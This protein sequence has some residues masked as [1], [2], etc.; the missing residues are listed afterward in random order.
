MR[1]ELGRILDLPSGEIDPATRFRDLGLDSL[2]AT[3]LAAAI[4]ER[5]GRPLPAIL[6]W[7]YPTLSSLAA[8]LAA[9]SRPDGTALVGTL[10]AA[11]A[12]DEP[13]AI[14]GMA[15][16]LPGGVASPE[17]FWD[18][19][20]NGIDAI[21]EVPA[22]RWPLNAYFDEDRTVP[23]HMNTRWGGF[24]DQIDGFDARFFSISPREAVETDPMQR[25]ALELA[26]EAVEEGGTLPA[27]LRGSRTG[28]FMGAMWSDY[29][30]LR[31][32][33][34]GHIQQHTG[35]GQDTSA[36]AGRIAYALGLQGPAMTVNTACSSSLVAIHLACR[37]L[38]D[39]ESDVALAGGVN[40]IL[41]PYGTVVMSKFGGMAPDGRCKAFDHRANGYVRGEGGAIVMLKR[42]SRALAD[43]D[44]VHGLIRGSAVNNDGFSNGFTAPNPNAQEAMLR[45]A[46]ARAGVDP[47]DIQYV[48]AHGTGT[49]L[50]DPIEA[51][52]LGAVLGRGRPPEQALR[53][54]SVKTNIGHLEAAAGV[55]GLIKV[56]LAMRH[57]LLPASLH[58]ERPNPAIP[59]DTLG[60]AVQGA[61]TPWPNPA[62]PPL[63]G[64][65]SFGFTG[66]NAHVL[67][68]GTVPAGEIMLPLS[69]PDGD[70]LRA[71]VQAIL[72]AVAGCADAAA[73]RAVCARAMAQ[74]QGSR[75]R[76]DAVRR[77]FRAAD[78]RAM[79]DRLL[80]A[81][82]SD[83]GAVPAG[84]RPPIV[85][86]YPGHGG[87]MP[88]MGRRLMAE[89]PIFRAALEAVSAAIE[90]HAGWSVLTELAGPPEQAR[91]HRADVVQP[92]LF[93]FQTAL[94]A[95]WRAW[96]IA[97]DL[98]IGHSVGE[99]A[100]AHT[101]GILD[102]DDAARLIVARG[103]LTAGVAG[104]GMAVIAAAPERFADLVDGRTL[105]W[106]GS[107]SPQSTL[108]TGAADALTHLLAVL[109]ERGI[110]AGRVNI[111]FA[112][113]GPAMAVLR[114]PLRQALAGIRPR[115]GAV[116]LVSTTTG[117]LLDGEESGADHWVR[118]LCDPVRF[119]DAVTRIAGL[120][121][122]PAFLEIGPD[123]VFGRAIE[124]TLATAG[125]RPAGHFPTLTREADGRDGAVDTLAALYERGCDVA[126]DRLGGQV[127]VEAPLLLPL[128]GRDEAACDQRVRD[129]AGWWRDHPDIPAA[130]IAFSA[131]RHRSHFVHRAA[132]AGIGQ[133]DLRR[134]LLSGEGMHRGS[135]AT[136]GRLVMV[137]PGQGWQWAGMGMMFGLQ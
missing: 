19:L 79:A 72:S 126:W 13:I 110:R 74:D 108:V 129:V 62:R 101:A 43:G 15:C 122:G 115:R 21:T 66:T 114:D 127:A 64:V 84:P 54:G 16:R 128:S 83:G 131:A 112:S 36:I 132:V 107:N 118:N 59:F 4:A 41:S 117:D 137:F 10:P 123:P 91:L 46:C 99:V 133:D 55:V 22:S 1:A 61:A 23:G 2:R 17:S 63:A 47:Q 92:V 90:R 28:I 95:L 98:V 5:L 56:V 76:D 27:S 30:R 88:G 31:G 42:L 124:E 39:G 96:G 113:H 134:R 29:A 50:G 75:N 26:W 125:H 85:F 68:E 65:S 6:L 53:I 102:L 77:V 70:G 116:P 48:E 120:A 32:T 11:A 82:A 34:T 40:L 58:L 3:G 103:R 20:R 37:S 60:L 8:F 121:A 69:A 73:L 109:K 24:L 106:A 12:A 86:L 35:T 45:E 18:L 111:A 100:A 14:V 67:V 80:A 81:L 33:D 7:Q 93:A 44:T 87:Q 57:G 89:E 104:G 97:P 136:G 94:T 9:G 25:L 38:R 52:A 105:H 78:P 135:S 130:D 51:G 119:A 49:A 71:A